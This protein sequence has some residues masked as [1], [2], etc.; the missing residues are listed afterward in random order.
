MIEHQSGEMI[1]GTEFLTIT[2]TAKP[3]DKKTYTLTVHTK[4]GATYLGAIRWWSPWRRYVFMPANNVV[5][6]AACLMEIVNTL[7]QLMRERKR[8]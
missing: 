8:G 6:D 1:D 4:T 3:D 7:G 5:F 2:F